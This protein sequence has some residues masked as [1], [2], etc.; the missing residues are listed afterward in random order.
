MAGCGAQT[1]QLLWGWGHTALI[2][3]WGTGGLYRGVTC[4]DMGVFWLWGEKPEGSL[5]KQAGEEATRR[6]ESIPAIL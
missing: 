6:S 1:Q 5:D 2:Q 3:R 4:F